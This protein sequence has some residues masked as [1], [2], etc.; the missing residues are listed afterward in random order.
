MR[1]NPSCFAGRKVEPLAPALDFGEPFTYGETKADNRGAFGKALAD[2]GR[3]NCGEEGKTPLLVF[4]CDLA[5]SVMT[6]AFRKAC[7]SGFVQCGIQ[8][9][10]T[11]TAS[12]AAAAAGVVSVWADFG[13]FGMDEVYNQQRLNDINHAGNKT[14]LT[15]VGL[16]VGEDGKTHQCIDYVGLLRNTCREIGRASCRERV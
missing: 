14:V 5:S 10:A 3:L 7:P 12:G 6:E 1:Q 4:D 16:D 9:H 15:H 8:E 11:A 2:V 13:V